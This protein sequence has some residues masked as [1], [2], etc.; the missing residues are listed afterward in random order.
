[1]AF[2]LLRGSDHSLFLRYLA[3]L[4]REVASITAESAVAVELGEAWA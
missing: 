1:M 3:F 2:W 4:A